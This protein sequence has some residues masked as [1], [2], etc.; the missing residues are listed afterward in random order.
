MILD[1]AEPRAESTPFDWSRR[2]CLV[3]LT[4]DSSVSNASTVTTMAA[5][6]TTMA[7]PLSLP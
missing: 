5:P 7:A 6:L 2:L 3:F 1:R 4:A